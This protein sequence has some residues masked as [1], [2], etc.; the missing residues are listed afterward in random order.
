MRLARKNVEE[1]DSSET[2]VFFLIVRLYSKPLVNTVKSKECSMFSVSIIVFMITVAVL[3]L[4][5]NSVMVLD[6]QSEGCE[7]HKA[8]TAGTSEHDP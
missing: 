8:A 7:V 3:R 4:Y 6:Y 5:S 2:Q 1:P